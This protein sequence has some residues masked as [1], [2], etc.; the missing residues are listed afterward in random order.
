M[1]TSAID[2]MAKLEARRARADLGIRALA[3]QERERRRREDA[4]AKII[5]GGALLAFFRNEPIAARALMPRL[6]PLIAER[7][8]ELVARLLGSGE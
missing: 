2:K 1:R 4:R 3:A 5:L 7:D 8:R 6:L